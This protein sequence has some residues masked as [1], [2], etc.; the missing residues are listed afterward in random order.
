MLD[1]GGQGGQEVLHADA[2]R[3]AGIGAGQVR[4]SCVQHVPAD[5]ALEVNAA[6]RRDIAMN[7]FQYAPHF[8]RQH[9]QAAIRTAPHSGC[10]ATLEDA[11]GFAQNHAANA[12][13]IGQLGF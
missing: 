6:M 1:G 4:V 9:N 10:S 8:G 12:E 3:P 11:D 13:A 7:G 5:A 2:Y